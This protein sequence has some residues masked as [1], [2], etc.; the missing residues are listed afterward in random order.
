[1]VLHWS[2]P[3][4]HGELVTL[5]FVGSLLMMHDAI[6]FPCVVLAFVGAL[7]PRSVMSGMSAMQPYPRQLAHGLGGWFRMAKTQGAR[8]GCRPSRGPRAKGGG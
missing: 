1:M 3:K 5:D 2:L 6:M 4:S 7:D 8:V